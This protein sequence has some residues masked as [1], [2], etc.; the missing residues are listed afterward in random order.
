M[1]R[2]R[3]AAESNPTIATVT[4][5]DEL[6][7]VL[8][9]ALGELPRAALWNVPARNLTFTGRGRLLKRLGEVLQ[10]G[11]GPAVGHALRGLA[12]R[13]GRVVFH[14]TPTGASWMNQIEI[15]NGIITRK[16]IRCGT[17]SSVK[18]LDKAIESF[19]AH[20]NRRHRI[21]AR[22][23]RLRCIGPS[24]PSPTQPDQSQVGSFLLGLAPLRDR[25]LALVVSM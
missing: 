9:Q 13:R 5:P 7:T 17:F 11:G 20:W 12:T 24:A 22:W 15:W 2:A 23:W 1:F 21:G 14:F 4:T 25:R 19:V 16:L 6:E 10:A 3:L 18:A 8:F